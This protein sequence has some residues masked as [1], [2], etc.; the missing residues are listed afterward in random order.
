MTKKLHLDDFSTDEIKETL[1]GVRFP[2]DIAIYNDDK[3]SENYFNTG[4]SIRSAHCFLV[5]Q[6]HLIKRKKFYRKACM[7]AKKYENI[8][9]HEDEHQFLENID[10]KNLVI[11]ERRQNIDT[12]PIVSFS[13][14]DNPVLF[15]G[16]EKFGIPDGILN[17]GAP[18]VTIPIYGLLNDL[19]L[20]CAITV[21]LF[22]YTNKYIFNKGFIK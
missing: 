16:S 7:G 6:I 21:A 9:H 20:A 4:S 14:P 13:Y 12:Q 3:D 19:N 18:C 11:F 22:D 8:R 2:V 5:N 1:S 17:T 15:F 10:S